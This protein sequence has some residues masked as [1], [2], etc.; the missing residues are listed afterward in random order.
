[1]RNLIKISFLVFL[2]SCE[3]IRDYKCICYYKSEQ[4]SIKYETYNVRNKK[5]LV[6]SYCKSLEP[7]EN[8]YNWVNQKVNCEIQ[9]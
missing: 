5:S 4:D 9:E 7:L 2:I 8:N 3:R 1:M 6:K